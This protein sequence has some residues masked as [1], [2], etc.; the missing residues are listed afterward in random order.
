[1]NDQEEAVKEIFSR[2]AGI[3]GTHSEATDALLA[4]IRTAVDKY[5]PDFRRSDSL[6]AS[7]I[8]AR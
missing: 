2:E 5:L 3:Y 4:A 8:E 7:A 6:G 1:M